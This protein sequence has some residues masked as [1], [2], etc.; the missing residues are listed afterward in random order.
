MKLSEFKQIVREEVRR[1]LRESLS[2][3]PDLDALAAKWNKQAQLDHYER[4]IRDIEREANR[5]FAAPGSGMRVV[6]VR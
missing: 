3:E 6:G 4:Q 1:T 5:M 2:Y